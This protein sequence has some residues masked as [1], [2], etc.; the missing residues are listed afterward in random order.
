MGRLNSRTVDKIVR[1]EENAS[2]VEKADECRLAKDSK[3]HR[4]SLR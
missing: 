3:R 1:D 4:K 2:E